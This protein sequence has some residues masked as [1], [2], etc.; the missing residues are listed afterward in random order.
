MSFYSDRNTIGGVRSMSVPFAARGSNRSAVT[1]AALPRTEQSSPLVSVNSA[2]KPQDRRRPDTM[3]PTFVRAKQ[4]TQL[5][6]PITPTS[7]AAKDNV[8]NLRASGSDLGSLMATLE[9]DVI[10][11]TECLVS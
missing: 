5:A 7:N 1:A 11:L 10:T 3:T 6:A 2:S 9:V 8:Q 4:A